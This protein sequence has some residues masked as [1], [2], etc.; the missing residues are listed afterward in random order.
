MPF[1]V[2]CLTLAAPFALPLAAA[3]ALVIK[4]RNLSL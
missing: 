3:W 4:V 1:F 2:E